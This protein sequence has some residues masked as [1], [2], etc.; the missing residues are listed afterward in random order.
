MEHPGEFIAEV[1]RRH[2]ISQQQLAIR[3]G[4]TQSAISRLEQGARSPSIATVER[5]LL[6]MGE[7]LDLRTVPLEGIHDADQVRRT[8]RLSMEQRLEQA[9]AW[10]SFAHEILGQARRRSL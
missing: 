10:N 7:Q 9:F 4:T 8:R 1:R 5:L 3:A 6:V 2:G